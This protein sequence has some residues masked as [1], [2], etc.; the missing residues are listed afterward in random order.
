MWKRTICC[1]IG[2]LTPFGAN[3]GLFT[4]DVGG[5]L[6][7]HVRGNATPENIRSWCEGKP[8]VR[9]PNG[10][11]F[12]TL[13]SWAPAPLAYAFSEAER[14]VFGSQGGGGEVRIT[15]YPDTLVNAGVN[16]DRT[17]SSASGID[18]KINSALL[19]FTEGIVAA[20]MLDILRDM[21]S[22]DAL[23]G[24]GLREW[25]EK[26]PNATAS[27]L[28]SWSAKWPG[29]SST[30]L[31]W[32]LK[33]IRTP[34]HSV[35]TFIFAHELSH[36]ALRLPSV[37]SP[38]DESLSRE[39]R[40][41]AYGFDHIGVAGPNRTLMASRGELQPTFV[42]AFLAA[43]AG[44]ERT[45]NDIIVRSAGGSAGQTVAG[46][47]P[48][49]NWSLR[50]NALIDRWVRDCAQYQATAM[51]RS[52]FEVLVA[53]ARNLVGTASRLSEGWPH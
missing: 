6:V 28:Q 36:I 13:Y 37:A 53:D 22:S 4:E 46:I 52:G 15:I 34:A 42:I 38:A 49:R 9:Y 7:V 39:I 33:Y 2:L 11:S 40:V 8:P 29:P 3:A 12:H 5:C 18:I 44:F 24:L 25:L 51:C 10:A 47:F 35:Y 23:P 20:Y 48:S 14:G 50:A 27:N 19:D 21:H 31:Q 17:E 41:D 1:I 43:T 45:R 32:N 30:T 16:I 26:V